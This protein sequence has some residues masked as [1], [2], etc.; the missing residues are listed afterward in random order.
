MLSSIWCYLQLSLGILLG[1]A[2]IVACVG[3]LIIGAYQRGE[4]RRA[5]ERER[6]AGRKDYGG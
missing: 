4:Y 3:G 1:L 2:V 6:R 5:V